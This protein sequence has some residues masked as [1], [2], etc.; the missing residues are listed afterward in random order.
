MESL[1]KADKVWLKLM[2]IG[3][4]AGC[5]Q[6]ESRSFSFHGY[7]FP[8]CARCTGIVIG[9][10]IGVIMY[11]MNLRLSIPVLILLSIPCAVDG[12]TQ[13]FTSYVSNNLKRIITG[14]LIGIAYIQFLIKAVIFIVSI[15]SKLVRTIL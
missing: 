6:M 15:I 12:L 1:N 2:H 4:V 10:I 9:H 5:H 13:E 3:H 8:L 14:F 7:Q 11:V